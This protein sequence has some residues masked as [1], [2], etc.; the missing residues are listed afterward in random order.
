MP[1]NESKSS[2][3]LLASGF[4]AGCAAT[5]VLQRVLTKSRASDLPPHHSEKPS[6]KTSRKA[7]KIPAAIREEQLSRHTL[8]FGTEGMESLRKARVCV[9]GVGGVGSHAAHMLAR[10]GLGY[11]HL[12]DFDQ[13]TVSSLNRHACAVLA[14][15]GRPKVT[16]LQEYLQQI[17][18]DERYLQIGVDATMFTEGTAE[19]LLGSRR[20]WDMVVDCIDDIPTKTALVAYCVKHKIPVISCMSAGGKADPTRMLLTDLKSAAKDPLATK[21]RLS[22]QKYPTTRDDDSFL[23]DMERLAIVYSHEKTVVQLAEFTEEQKAEGVHNF[24]AVDGMRIRIVPVQGTMPALMG[25]AM[26]AYCLNRLS[27]MKPFQPTTVEPLAKSTRHKMYQRFRNQ[28]S[29]IK[30]KVL[31]MPNA[32]SRPCLDNRE[33]ELKCELVTVVP[34][35]GENPSVTYWVGDP[36]IDIYE[37]M[38]YLCEIWR[39]RCAITGARLGTVLQLARW[40]WSKPSTCDNLV[41]L[42][43]AVLKHFDSCDPNLYKEQMDPSKRE[44]IEKRLA[45]CRIDR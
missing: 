43:A 27:A 12:V 26:A 15:V 39:N 37:D 28:E 41:L 6:S 21:L 2:T 20:K 17:C 14:D 11:L 4:F 24:G 32:T 3:L 7:R 23:E 19:A 34:S 33:P 5:V 30:Q 45:L 38:E 22:L 10:S 18:P 36:Q 35:S 29:R 1:A 13:V 25:Q 31:A 9:I 16:V 40:D 44:S 8:Y 42:S